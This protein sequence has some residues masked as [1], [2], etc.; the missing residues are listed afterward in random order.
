[1]ICC[2]TSETP[3]YALGGNTGGN[4][5][6]A[7]KVLMTS[8]TSSTIAG[9]ALSTARST[10]GAAAN[11]GSA[12]YYAGGQTG[13]TA[14]TNVATTDKLTYSSETTAVTTTANLSQARKSVTGLSE[15]S[16]K[17]YFAGGDTGAGVVRV[18]T[19]DKLTFSGDSTAAVAGAN[20]SSA[21]GVVAG[22]TNGS[23]DGYWFGGNN[24][25]G[26]AVTTCDK[27]VFSSDTTSAL[28]TGN[29]TS[30]QA[31]CGGT[32]DG[33][34]KGYITGGANFINKFTFSSET[35]AAITGQLTTGASA[36][37]SS[38]GTNAVM[39]GGAVVQTAVRALAFSTDTNTGGLGS[40]SPGTQAF[41]GTCTAA[42]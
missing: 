33:S 12:G 5:A 3:M 28:T 40:I 9:A 1:M 16:T 19:T 13:A 34:T 21:R 39:V 24:S 30:A 17:A 6:T 8:L 27:T 18:A 42:L 4:V 36:A 26:S 22:V 32:S 15:R 35:C 10:L 41:A 20:L 37:V 31:A 7:Q 14:G 38:N 23:T 11:P 25:A 2:C 29:L